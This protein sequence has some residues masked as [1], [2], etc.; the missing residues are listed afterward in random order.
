MNEEEKEQLKKEIIEE[1]EK[2]IDQKLS[3]I[4]NDISSIEEYMGEIES[5]VSKTR[6]ILEDHDI[7]TDKYYWQ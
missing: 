1:L 7:R 2:Y 3:K 4:E 6:K 5:R